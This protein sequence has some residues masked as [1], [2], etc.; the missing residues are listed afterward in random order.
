MLTGLQVQNFRSLRDASVS[1]LKRL[2]LVTGRNAGG[3]TSLLEAVFLNCG[4]A[5]ANLL[6]SINTFR[7]DT[8]L[9]AETDRV[10]STCFSNLDIRK[11]ITISADEKRQLKSRPRVLTIDGQTSTQTKLGQARPSTFLS[12]VHVRF[13]GANGKSS[14]TVS[15]EYSDPTLPVGLPPASPIHH[16]GG[17]NP[18]DVI[19]GQFLSPYVREAYHETYNQLTEVIKEK[20]VESLLK[21]LQ[22]I[23]ADIHG[24]EALTEQGQPMIYVDT[25]ASKLLPASVLGAGFFHVLRLALSMSRIERGILLIDELEDGLHYKTFP[26]VLSAII[27]FL[28]HGKDTQA[29]IT[30]HSS[31]LI[32]SALKVVQERGFNDFCL[33]NMTRSDDGTKIAYFSPDE[34]AYAKEL[35]AE[36]R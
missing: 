21:T 28:E 6:F 18:K 36:L 13:S 9:H 5:N 7:G 4:G 2:N 16:T 23:Q 22:L 34:V 8:V 14:S 10:F 30:T 3:K 19:F 1:K 29:F 33:L 25:G 35:E 15:M 11:T 31:E 20:G 17:P 12:G 24:L 26:R 32:D 27:D